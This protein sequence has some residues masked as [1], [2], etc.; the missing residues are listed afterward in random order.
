MTISAIRLS[1]F[2]ATLAAS[3]VALAAPND[4][5]DCT[6][7]QKSAQA[8]KA[9]GKLTKALGELATCSR[10]V[11]PKPMQKQCSTMADA[12]KASQP[13]IVLSAKDASGNDVTAVTV[14]VDGT[15]VTSN[16]DGSPLP[17]DPGSHEMKFEADGATTVTK[18]ITVDAD[19]KAQPVA[20]DLDLNPPKAA[21]KAKEIVVVEP[22]AAGSI[23]DTTEDPTKRYYFIG[24]RY[25][26]DV[27]PQFMINMFVG[28]GETFF[29][30]AVSIEADLRKDRFSLI[31]ALTYAD[32]SFGNVLFV[33][34]NTDQTD[35]GNWSVV[36]SGIHGIFGSA[37]LLWSV[38]IA[39]H[40]DFEYG[41]E[42]GLGIIFGS[43]ENN[44]V[45]TPGSATFNPANYQ[46]CT[47]M[48]QNAGANGC[49]ITNHSGATAPG[50]INGYEEPSWVNGGSKP[51]IF[52]MI[53]FPQIGLRYKP[54]KQLES[55]LGVGFSL[56]GFWFSLS[57][58][59]GF[60]KTA[61]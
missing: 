54:I 8:D 36:N 38:H 60:E 58:D 32:Y 51:N 19:G 53:N 26:G 2:L 56:T 29:A 4:K 33:Q 31:P 13:T 55:R 22:D 15:V 17:V 49:Q 59:Y 11:C 16:L 40:W 39:N 1:I 20:V 6:A 47:T 9:A 5:A 50:H 30:N 41:A 12:V 34:K 43:L 37:D 48:S 52:P 28:G 42:F 57:A 10:P 14:S 45:Y 61:K 44:W 7:A 25:R 35:P 18:T 21:A 3:G 23:T 24:M 46:L 27:V